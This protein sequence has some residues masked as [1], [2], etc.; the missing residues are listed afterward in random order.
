MDAFFGLGQSKQT[1]ENQ[2]EGERARRRARGSSVWGCS[3]P[4]L[5]SVRPK[6]LL[7]GEPFCGVIQT[8]L[9]PEDSEEL[10]QV[11]L[12]Q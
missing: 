8:H 6:A 2:Q 4:S 1:D 3:G 5:N 9:V 12:H 10:S 7:K 11:T